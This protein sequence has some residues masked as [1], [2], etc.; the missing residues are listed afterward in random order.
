MQIA[1]LS[2]YHAYMP[3][4]AG[5]MSG[6]SA[7]PAGTNA[8]PFAPQDL[9]TISSEAQAAAKAGC[10]S[11]AAR[12]YQCSSGQV[13]SGVSSNE[14]GSFVAAHEAEHLAKDRVEAQ[15]NDRQVVSQSMRLFTAMCAECGSTFVAG[16]EA[17]TVTASDQPAGADHP[18]MQLFD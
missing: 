13:T 11:C 1:H 15:A 17:K 2:M 4:P 6:A 7:Q 18:V 9:L 10:A 5:G 14:S 12:S 8:D 16:G 3:Q